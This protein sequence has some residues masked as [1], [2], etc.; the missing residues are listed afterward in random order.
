MLPRN[1]EDRDDDWGDS[2]QSHIGQN[3]ELKLGRLESIRSEP[4]VILYVFSVDEPDRQ[5]FALAFE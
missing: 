1:E 2:V 3:S 5:R 4:S